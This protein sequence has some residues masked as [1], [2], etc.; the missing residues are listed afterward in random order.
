MNRTALISVALVLTG[1]AF[2]LISILRGQKLRRDV[3]DGLKLK[4]RTMTMLMIFFLAGYF[5]F[6]GVLVAS[7]GFSVELIV[8]AVFLGGA[9]FVFIVIG[10]SGT[11]IGRI[12]RAE[13]TRAKALEFSRTVMNSISDAISVID[14]GDYRI[15]GCN[16]VF[17]K[18]VGLA[19]ADA[20]GKTCYELTHRVTEPC[21]PPHDTCPLAQT[22]L[23]GKYSVAEHRHFTGS[24]EKMVVEVSTSPIFDENG[25]V[26]QVV[27]VSRDIT[28]RKR[29][30]DKLRISAEQWQLT[31]DAINDGVSIHDNEMTIVRANK[32]LGEFLGTPSEDLL[33]RKCH[34]VFHNSAEPHPDCPLRRAMNSQKP[35][36]SEFLEPFLNRWLSIACFPIFGAGGKEISG[37][38]H[39]ARDITDRKR[40]E[41]DIRR[42]NEELELKVKERT[43]QLLDAQEELIRKE[44]LAIL[45]QLAG[46]VGHELRNPLGVMSNA[47]YYLQTVLADR[48]DTVREYLDIIKNEIFGAER[49]VSDLLDAVRTKP[50]RPQLVSAEDVIRTGLEKCRIPENITVDIRAETQQPVLVDPLQMK[51]VFVN[52]ISNAVEAMPEGGTL[53]ISARVSGHP[54]SIEI[55]IADTGEGITP[56]NMKK[57]FQ[58]L[59]TTKARGIGLGLVVVKNITEANSGT[60]SVDSET[61]KGT[62]FTVTLPAKGV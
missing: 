25:K 60:V 32:S 51:Q 61:G 4:W 21:H 22:V 2:M 14:A 43:R 30:E 54:S 59:F 26:A 29:I 3:P 47:V 7:P 48:D 8:G 16:S 17:L 23:I 20:L 44:K 40:A 19:E 9:C 52:L 18:Q 45:G 56:E 42:L 58:P 1:A 35:E 41:D 28:E 46:S 37:T 11:T 13:E 6:A 36:F 55:S 39:I 62:T 27:H 49:I 10:L 12:K 57:L 15:V 31:F 34:K 24:G 33:G 53:R 5:I 38:V 50:P